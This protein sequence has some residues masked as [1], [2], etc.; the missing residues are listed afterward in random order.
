[1]TD[2][3]QMGFRALADPTRRTI[4][5]LLGKQD[6]TIAEVAENFC[7]TRAAVK[8]HLTILTEGDLIEVRTIGR[9]RVN[10]L[11]TAG[12]KRV[13]NWFDY[14]DSFWDQRLDNLKT[15]IEKEIQ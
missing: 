11:N 14:F 8:K 6:M 9:T 5:R 7:M 2:Q 15:E 1:M 4:L 3:E 12:L 13:V 10:A